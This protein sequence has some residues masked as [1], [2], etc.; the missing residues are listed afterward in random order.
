MSISNHRSSFIA[1]FIRARFDV[2]KLRSDARFAGLDN[3]EHRPYC[4]RCN[5]MARMR[6][7]GRDWL[8]DPAATDYARRAGCGARFTIATKESTT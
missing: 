7:D 8:C 1:A 4:L 6:P 3:P 5:S 2:E